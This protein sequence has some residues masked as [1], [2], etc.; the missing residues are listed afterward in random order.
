MNGGN[1]WKIEQKE[2]KVRGKNESKNE[3]TIK[4]D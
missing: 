4:K 3:Q 1:K 2:K